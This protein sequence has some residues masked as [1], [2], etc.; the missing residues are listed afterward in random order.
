MLKQLTE[1]AGLPTVLD[2]PFYARSK[3]YPMD[4]V[5][6]NEFSTFTPYVCGIYIKAS[7]CTDAASFYMCD[8]YPEFTA[9]GKSIIFPLTVLLD[10]MYEY[11]PYVNFKHLEVGYVKGMK[12]LKEL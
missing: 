4:V 11:P 2:I 6:L 8:P 9:D 5:A 7:T 1:V 3:I 12:E 10:V